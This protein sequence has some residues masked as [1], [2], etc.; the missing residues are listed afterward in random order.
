MSTNDFTNTSVVIV[1]I[2]EVEL[3]VANKREWCEIHTDILVS[4]V[5]N[6]CALGRMLYQSH[7]WN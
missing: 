6:M 7:Y 3:F 2:K 1:L 4:F 5:E